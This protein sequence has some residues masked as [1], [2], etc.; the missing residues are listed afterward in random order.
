MIFKSLR[1]K[2]EPR[3]FSQSFYDLGAERQEKRQ[4]FLPTPSKL[5]L[6]ISD[7]L[8]KPILTMGIPQ[9]IIA[10]P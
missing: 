5:C 7:L 6:I 10:A 8:D 2:Q 1:E 4:A 9:T 3:S